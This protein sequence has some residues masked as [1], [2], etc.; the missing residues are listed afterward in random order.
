MRYFPFIY[1]AVSAFLL[2][3]CVDNPN[4]SDKPHIEFEKFSRTIVD[5]ND[6]FKVFLHVEDGDGDLGLENSL[7]MDCDPCDLVTPN[8]CINDPSWDL[9]L[10]DDRTGCMAQKKLPFVKP[11]GNFESVEG[12][13]R[14]SINQGQYCCRDKQN[15]QLFCPTTSPTDTINFWIFIK[16]RS[17]KHSD[18]VYLPPLILT[19]N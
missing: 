19:C 18:T 17:G 12:T 13:I 7:G 15:P 14:V 9:F 6:S 8:S 3:S 4:F 5:Q 16:D 10:I 1:L 2:S 11:L